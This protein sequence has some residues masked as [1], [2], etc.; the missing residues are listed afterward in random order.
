MAENGGIA[1]DRYITNP[2]DMAEGKKGIQIVRH[3]H[4]LEQKYGIII[5]AITY[6]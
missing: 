2:L 5:P 1:D 4:Q 3:P 6:L